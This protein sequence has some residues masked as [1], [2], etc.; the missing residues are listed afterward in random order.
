[1]TYSDFVHYD[2]GRLFWKE[3]PRSHFASDMAWRMFNNRDAGNE[4][5]SLNVHG[6]VSL[7]INYKMHRAHRIIWDMHN[8]PIPEGMDIDHMNGIRSD[9]RVENLRLSTRSQNIGNKLVAKR[10]KSRLMGV[11]R[12]NARNNWRAVINANGK[13]VTIGRYPTKG[14]AAVAYAKASIQAYGKFAGVLRKS[15]N[16]PINKWPTR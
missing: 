13:Y 1:M 14:L 8:G 15:N 4:A 3:R 11:T 6:Y 12:D 2:N 5:G 10:S 7:C 16:C 9:N